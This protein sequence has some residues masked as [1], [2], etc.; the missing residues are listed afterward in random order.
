MK[1]QTISP[2][3]TYF[4]E[5]FKTQ[6]VIESSKIANTKAALKTSIPST[7]EISRQRKI[8]NKIILTATMLLLVGGAS[9]MYFL[10]ADFAQL[11]QS[12]INS[13]LGFS[14]LILTLA[15]LFFKISFLIYN[16]YLYF[17]YKP[18]ES[19]SDELLPT[20][21]VIVPAYNEGKLVWQT[22][23]SI[24]NSDFPTHKLQILA[25]DDGNKDDT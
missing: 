1:T 18:I 7:K 12:R 5:D 20:C 16:V 13:P 2:N 21:T 22:L 4:R 17:T 15:L 25:I 10:Q 19:V 3:Q 8:S 14:F 11:N 24:A 23:L 6:S 9:L